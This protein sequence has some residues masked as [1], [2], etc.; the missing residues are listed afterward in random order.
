MEENNDL[1][2][3]NEASRLLGVSKLTL[4]NWDAQGT[5]KAIRIGKRR[6]RRYKRQN[7]ERVLIKKDN[8]IDRE[9]LKEYLDKNE[10]WI[11]EAPALPITLEDCGKKM[12]QIGT[13]FKPSFKF[14]ITFSERGYVQWFLSL[15]ETLENCKS[16]FKTLENEPE[17]TKSFY[18][19]MNE[20][21]RE[22]LRELTR[23]EFI[24]LSKLLTSDLLREFDN[25]NS[26]ISK[27]W[28]I[29]LVIEHYGPFLDQVYLPHFEKK[30]GDQKKAKEAFS[31]LTLPAKLSFVGNERKGLLE[32]ILKFLSSPKERNLLEKSSNAEYLTYLK[33]ENP[34]FFNSL[35][36]HQKKYYWIQNNYEKKVI[37]EMSDFL[38]FIKEA[39][40]G[41]VLEKLKE[42]FDQLNNEKNV[43]ERQNRLVKELNLDEKTQKEIEHI[44]EIVWI[45]DERKEVILK[46]LHVFFF[47]L[48]EL[49]RRTKIEINLLGYARI[50][51]IPDILQ[52]N[53]N[54]DVLEER[55]K[56]SIWIAQ[57][58]KLNILT[59]NE[60]LLIKN[61]LVK[62]NRALNT[63]I[64]GSIANRG[65][66]PIVRGKVKI[67]LDPRDK[68]MS[69]NEILVTSMT[70]PDFLP[71]MRNARAVI[72][73]EGGI[74]CHA[75]IVAREMNKPCIIGTR[76]ATK[77]LKT[78]D[79][80]E[81][82]MNHGTIKILKRA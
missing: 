53:F 48:E 32:I 56:G 34:S 1:V 36:E 14:C 69:N 40:R 27:F 11:Q 74:T 2:D 76:F 24:N 65:E 13:Y 12:T 8:E 81:L 70:R 43:I 28:K 73:N 64:H 79:E 82:R 62:E 44:R 80:V 26:V 3:I 33:F 39:L 19:E 61:K 15:D 45:K 9:T 7:I 30:I 18:K 29:S 35:L 66:D 55:N 31:V 5:L 41:K 21:F 22:T 10:F 54:L 75:A 59:G 51:E 46:V 38:E 71:L 52:N 16:Q 77:V 37:L 60:V 4:R 17:K 72:T 63:E 67:I 25:L 68:S 57:E 20:N 42:E 50:D 23:F 78:G 47:F 58:E 6:D 49:S